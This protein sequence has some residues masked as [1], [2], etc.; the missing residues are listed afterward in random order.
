[1]TKPLD[2][3]LLSESVESALTLAACER[4]PEQPLQ[5]GRLLEALA[6]VDTLGDWSRIWLHTG[7][8]SAL[9]LAEVL[10]TP[11]ALEGEHAG[12]EC[13]WRGVPL[14]PALNAAM[15][16][17]III[18][19]RYSLI[20]VP[21]GALALALLADP[22]AGS[23]SKLLSGG[24]VGHNDLLAIVQSDLLGTDLCDLDDVLAESLNSDSQ[25]HGWTDL[26]DDLD[27]FAEL[28]R[29]RP[30]AAVLEHLGIVSEVVVELAPEL[31][32]LATRPARDILDAATAHGPTHEPSELQILVALTEHP[33]DALRSAFRLFG[34]D[35]PEVAA[36]AA[37]RTDAETSRRA[38]TS[39]A[40]VVLSILSLVAM[41]AVLVLL[42]RHAVG[43]GSLWELLLIP[44]I[45][46]GPPGSGT[47]SSLATSILFFITCSPLVGASKL[48]ATA[49]GACRDFA[50]RQDILA[51]TGV[52]LSERQQRRRIVWRR[53]GV[54][55]ALL[56]SRNVAQLPERLRRLERKIEHAKL[57]HQSH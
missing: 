49:I 20:P 40:T 22:A 6:R 7:L 28:A 30:V 32:H 39:T 1:M 18:A 15:Q 41:W 29:L 4:P 27:L 43:P 21:P 48:V 50:E 33:S 44:L 55:R 9:G 34:L 46:T 45:N 8:P 36:E 23:T 31:R 12:R 25:S 26:G 53:R 2:Q 42:I 52:R 24:T 54:F 37:M 13:S 38:T 16:T 17:L 47:L 11:P 10:D 14:S 57:V 5:T 51:A 35:G 3:L 56:E 19:D